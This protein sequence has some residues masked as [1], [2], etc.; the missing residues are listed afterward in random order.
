MPFILTDEQQ[1]TLSVGFKTAAGNPAKVDGLPIWASSD[2]SI[3]SLVVAADGLSAVAVSGALGSAQI[4]VQADADLGEGVR[5]IT[6]TLDI[7]VHAAEAVSV[8]VVVGT[9][10]LKPVVPAPEP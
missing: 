4:S 7:E 5:T 9:P 10:E 6:S 8:L 1:V 2:E 3:V